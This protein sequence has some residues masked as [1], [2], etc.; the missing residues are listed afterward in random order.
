MSKF[1]ST[2]TPAKRASQRPDARD[3]TDF[4]RGN[5]KLAA[6]LPNA[7]RLAALQRDCLALMPVQFA[8]CMVL[9]VTDGQ[10]QVAVPNAALATRMK[11]LLP[12]LHA[13]LREKGWQLQ[14]IGL[15]IQ[16]IAPVPPPKPRELSLPGNAVASFADLDSQIE[17]HPRNAALKEAIRMLVERRRTKA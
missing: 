1:P 17:T 10:M 2:F 3:A 4:L 8:H 9:Q 15:K 6:L 13:D 11:Q 12:K 14:G 16:V 5:D 7:T